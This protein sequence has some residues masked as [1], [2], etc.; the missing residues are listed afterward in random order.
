MIIVVGVQDHTGNLQDEVSKSSSFSNIQ[1]MTVRFS[2]YF[3]LFAMFKYRS[4]NLRI[5]FVV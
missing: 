2:C 3:T 5:L 1:F 4:C